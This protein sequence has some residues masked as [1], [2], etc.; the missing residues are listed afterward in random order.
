MCYETIKESALE[1]CS[2]TESEKFRET[3]SS[4]LRQQHATATRKASMQ[5]SA[6]ETIYGQHF[7]KG[8]NLINRMHQM[9]EEAAM[10]FEFELIRR[11]AKTAFEEVEKLKERSREKVS[12]YQVYEAEKQMKK[13]IVKAAT[14]SGIS[15]EERK[16]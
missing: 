11:K 13:T 5:Q 1:H 14:R 7:E 10:N 8:N 2:L 15:R 16:S 9:R 6:M 4:R 3:R 12:R